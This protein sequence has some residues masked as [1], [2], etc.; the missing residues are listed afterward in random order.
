[1]GVSGV[2]AAE[3]SFTVSYEE[4]A[5]NKP[6]SG[7][8]VVFGFGDESNKIY[9]F[10]VSQRSRKGGTVTFK[11]YDKSIFFGISSDLIDITYVNVDEKDENSG[12]INTLGVVHSIAKYFGLSCT[13]RINTRVWGLGQLMMKKSD[14][15]GKTV[16]S[17]LETISTAWCGYFVIAP[18]YTL[19]FVLFGDDANTLCDAKTHSEIEMRSERSPIT[20]VIA[21]TGSDYYYATLKDDDGQK[22]ES[23]VLSTLTVQTDFASQEY[24]EMLLSRVQNYTYRSW[25]C[26]KAILERPAVLPT[27]SMM[28]NGYHFPQGLDITAR[29]IANSLVL[30]FTSTGIYA[31]LGSNEVVEDEYIYLGYISRKLEEKISDGEKLGNNTL[32]T[33]YQGIVHLG[34]KKKDKETGEVKQDRYGYSKATSD[35]VVKFSGSLVSEKIPEIAIKS[36]LS[37]FTA[38]YD[39]TTIDYDVIIDGDN[40]TLK[41]KEKEGE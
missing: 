3:F 28:L 23:D 40:V 20:Q 38:K 6:K 37:G 24:A 33:R 22:I 35:G 11:C 14:I 17:L 12:E 16:R 34:E 41:E 25:R 27:L 15:K 31:E 32:I 10:Y 30:N 39:D 18:N 29:L 19:D 7:A 5:K 36:D 8:E 2:S 9:V 4:Y 1:M 13:D 26:S 21:Y